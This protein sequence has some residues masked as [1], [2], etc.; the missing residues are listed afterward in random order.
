MREQ[1]VLSQQTS[2]EAQLLPEMFC[3]YAAFDRGSDSELLSNER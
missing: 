3:T 1:A 2:S